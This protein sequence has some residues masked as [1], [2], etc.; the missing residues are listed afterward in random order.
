M[1]GDE[2]TCAELAAVRRETVDSSDA[3]AEVRQAGE[4]LEAGLLALLF[5]IPLVVLVREYGMF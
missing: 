3:Y 2:T 5:E 1:I 4:D